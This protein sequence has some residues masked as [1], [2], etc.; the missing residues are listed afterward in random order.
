MATTF[1]IK[2]RSPGSVSVGRTP[3]PSL[4]KG[5]LQHPQIEDV[6][7]VKRARLEAD[8]KRREA[9]KEERKRFFVEL[10]GFQESKKSE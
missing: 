10:K 5:V 9:M 3:S 4:I 1:C 2:Y 8:K 6:I 7:E